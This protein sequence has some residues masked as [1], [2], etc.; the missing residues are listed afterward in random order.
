MNAIQYHEQFMDHNNEFQQMTPPPR[1]IEMESPT[2]PCA[3]HY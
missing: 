2:T 3:L 1:Q